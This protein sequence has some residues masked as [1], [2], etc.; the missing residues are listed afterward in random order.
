V[1]FKKKMAKT[2]EVLEENVSADEG[3]GEEILREAA[4]AIANFG[5]NT[6]AFTA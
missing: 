6:G 3:G 5:T 1:R 4:A 2:H